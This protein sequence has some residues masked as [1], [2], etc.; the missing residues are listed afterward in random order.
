MMGAQT[1]KTDCLINNTIGYHI[2]HDP[3]S[4][5]VMQPTLRDMQTW[6]EAKLNP[7]LDSTD[8]VRD[9]VAKARG[10][11]GVNNQQMKSFPGGFLMFSYSGSPNTMRGRSAP[12]IL[13]D[14]IDGYEITTEGD[15]VQLL[16]QRAATFGD[17]R[18]LIETST[19]TIKGVSKIEK[20]FEAGDQRRYWMPC[21]HCEQ[22]QTLQWSQVTWDKDEE[23]HLPETAR[24]ICEHNK[25]TITDGDKSWMLRNGEWRADKPFKG[26]ASF[27]LSELYS[28]WR[29]WEDIV[30]SFLDK[31]NAND[32][33]SFINVSLAETWE[34]AGESVDQHVLAERRE[35]YAAEV[36]DGVLV[37]TA[38][39]DVQKDRI[40]VETV[41]WGA[42][43]ES[44]G[45]DRTQLWGDPEETA[46]WEDL[47]R[48]L[49]QQWTNPDGNQLGVA[50]ACVDSGYLT[51][52]VY[53]W[54]APRAGRRI[55][56]VKG[57]AGEGKP[58]VQ[59]S[60]KPRTPGKAPKTMFAVG[61]DGVKGSI[62]SNLSRKEA[63]P[64]YCHF[65]LNYPNEFFEQLTAEKR[66]T[67]YRKGFPYREW[68]KTRAR[69][70][71][72][73][74]RVYAYAAISILNP[75]WHSFKSKEEQPKR[76][77]PTVMSQMQKARKNNV[78]R[79]KGGF[80][81]KWK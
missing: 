54:V 27:H 23:G 53:K 20:A 25:C 4:I 74:I 17:Q 10:R 72:L 14:E 70:E 79:R 78:N 5:M 59:K 60:P 12:I 51:S 76:P 21:P 9:R 49:L 37:L 11:E 67:K 1:G 15:Q 34:E 33:Q 55:Y 16:W 81:G 75:I 50:C 26:H 28:P 61:V 18:K 36:P 35:D 31:K 41:G 66:V 64:G 69:N 3:K 56:A 32:L 80:V 13:C 57:V 48:Y 68:V 30:Q 39:V 42:D 65:P 73:D 47:D 43:F 62:L 8:V 38:G 29:R 24:Y 52:S 6:M 22:W 40:E 63:G 58:V 45:I 71:A 7:M 44:W 46:V 2:A 77:Q 19:P